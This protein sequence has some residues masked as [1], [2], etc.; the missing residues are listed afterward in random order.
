MMAIPV[1]LLSNLLCT[2]PESS[3]NKKAGCAPCSAQQ[4][5]AIA[6]LEARAATAEAAL[7]PLQA[8]L[9]TSHKNCQVAM[10][11]S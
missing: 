10:Q 4:D 7:V 1:H 9:A 5:A 11:S 2:V 8:E 3:L 6:A